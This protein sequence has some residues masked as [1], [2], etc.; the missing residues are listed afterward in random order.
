MEGEKR[1]IKQNRT[2]FVSERREIKRKS[3]RKGYRQK[4]EDKTTESYSDMQ[5]QAKIDR[6]SQ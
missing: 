1:D 2:L 3:K 6:Q 4:D 5:T